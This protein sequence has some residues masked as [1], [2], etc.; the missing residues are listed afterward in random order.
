MTFFKNLKCLYFRNI[1][2][3]ITILRFLFIY[4]FPLI[5][6]ENYTF[7]NCGNLDHQYWNNCQCVY[8]C[9]FSTMFLYKDIRNLVNTCH[10]LM[11]HCLYY[12]FTSYLNSF[13]LDILSFL[14]S[15]NT[16]FKCYFFVWV[17]FGD[18]CV[19]IQLFVKFILYKVTDNIIV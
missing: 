16:I 19:F 15:N 3:T 11:M 17:I 12:I 10:F 18:F 6:I 9:V 14:Q 1:F 8:L 4:Y 2:I 7:F 13:C 5:S